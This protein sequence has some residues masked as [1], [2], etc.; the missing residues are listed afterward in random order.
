MD[1]EG[2]DWSNLARENLIGFPLW[3]FL[4]C[5]QLIVILSNLF[6]KVRLE[7][8]KTSTSFRCDGESERSVQRLDIEPILGTGELRCTVTCLETRPRLYSVSLQNCPMGERSLNVCSWCCLVD[9]PK[10]W[11]E[12]EEAIEVLG[13]LH[14]NCGLDIHHTVCPNCCGSLEEQIDQI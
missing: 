14:D 1:I 5:D 9:G 6:K 11:I 4:S 8:K 3:K 2:D 12:L 10:G 13:L 7:K